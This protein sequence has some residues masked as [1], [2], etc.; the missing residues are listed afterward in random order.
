MRERRKGRKVGGVGK[1]KEEKVKERWKTQVREDIKE[2]RKKHYRIRKK[3]GIMGEEKG[4]IWKSCGEKNKQ[5][6]EGR[7]IEIKKLGN[8]LTGRQASKE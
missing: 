5:E 4:G 1:M 8:V 3:G 2:E 7:D 6:R